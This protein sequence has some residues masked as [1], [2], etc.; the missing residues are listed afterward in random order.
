MSSISHLKRPELLWLFKAGSLGTGLLS[1][2]SELNHI[3]GNADSPCCTDKHCSGTSHENA[4]MA[5]TLLLKSRHVFLMSYCWR[6]LY[7][8]KRFVFFVMWSIVLK[9]PTKVF[10]VA[11]LADACSVCL[12]HNEFHISLLSFAWRVWGFFL[13]VFCSFTLVPARRWE[14]RI[15]LEYS[16][17]K[18]EATGCKGWWIFLN[19]Q[20]YSVRCSSSEKEKLLLCT[21]CFQTETKGTLYFQV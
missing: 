12:W 4:R 5:W 20:C 6:P 15:F 19:F 16:L 11:C 2:V 13:R 3:L 7:E 14:R 9:G 10:Y 1:E 18:P 21:Y 17:T 8:R